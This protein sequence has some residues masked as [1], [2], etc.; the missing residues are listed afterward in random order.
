MS[1]HVWGPTKRVSLNLG[2]FRLFPSP[3]DDCVPVFWVVH[4]GKL[5]AFQLRSF[6]KKK[7]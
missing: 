7:S 4:L 2:N 6:Q 5:Y 3:F 1:L